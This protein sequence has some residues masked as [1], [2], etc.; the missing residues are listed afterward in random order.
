MFV[1]YL[2]LEC[3]CLFYIVRVKADVRVTVYFIARVTVDIWV[4]VY[5]S[6]V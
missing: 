3:Y 1:F 6:Q 4:T 5:Y 2:R